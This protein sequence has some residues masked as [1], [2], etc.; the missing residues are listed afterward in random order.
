ML[1]R[2]VQLRRFLRNA[3]PVSQEVDH[4]FAE[5]CRRLEVRRCRIYKLAGLTS[6]A[7]AYHWRPLILLPESI[8]SYLDKAQL[9]DVLS[10]ELMHVKRWDFLWSLVTE[11]V[12]S[13]LFFHPAIW[14]GLR[15][16][17]RERELACDAAVVR[18]R[19]DRRPDYAE[20]L[21]R[22]A[23]VCLNKQRTPVAIESATPGSFL[24]L[25]VQTLLAEPK[26]ASL[27]KRGATFTSSLAM[28]A[29]FLIL[30][31]AVAIILQYRP[32]VAV[33]ALHS[34]TP[35]PSV[36][37]HR[38]QLHHSK[39]SNTTLR[40]PVLLPTVSITQ[41]EIVPPP[42]ILSLP[43]ASIPGVPVGVDNSF[44]LADSSR[45]NDS[46]TNSDRAEAPIPVDEIPV[47]RKSDSHKRSIALPSWRKVVIGAAVA[48]I[49]GL[50]MNGGS[51]NSEQTGEQ[52]LIS[53]PNP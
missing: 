19:Q 29:A 13:L 20:C 7:T 25:R 16:L 23:R 39:R 32:L 51:Q 53:K 15:N 44:R 38:S 10:H 4:I 37:I 47:P 40:T 22:I 8:E 34:I 27:W 50:V 2:R 45:A 31:P 14:L 48:A 52:N 18:H 17:R 42:P 36:S 9:E 24:A 43:S 30:W 28:L 5:L 6:P 21:T 33:A 1:Q 46:E 41:T 35:S 26:R 3:I 12:R 11:L 49:G